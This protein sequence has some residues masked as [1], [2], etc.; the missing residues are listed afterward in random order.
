MDFDDI[1][2]D[3]ESCGEPEE[4]EFCN[5]TISQATAKRN[6]DM[7]GKEVPEPEH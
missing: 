3:E 4:S 1:S 5:L 6:Y 7:A 2:D